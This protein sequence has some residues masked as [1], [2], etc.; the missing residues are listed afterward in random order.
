M[1][2]ICI[3][4]EGQT[5]VEFILRCVTPHL[6]GYQIT[7]YPSLLRAPSGQ[8]RGGRVTVERLVNFMMHEYHNADRVTSLVDFYGFQD[9][10]GRT[11]QQL[12]QAIFDGLV[13]GKLKADPRYVMPYVQ[14]HE[15]EALLFSDI[16]QFQF[17][18]DGWNEKVRT[19]LAVVKRNFETPEHINNSRETAPSKRILEIF[20]HRSY[21]KTEH[22][23]IIAQEIGLPAIRA[24]CRQFDAWMAALEA[25]G[26][27]Q[28]LSHEP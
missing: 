10:A 22:G 17:V 23:P 26:Q 28:K 4:C 2:R 24:H 27:P 15:F 25:W 16:E 7:A 1:T 13:G 20:E 6:M 3:V 8:H 19:S 21:N 5:E 12:E 11:R 18:L 14:M 9:A